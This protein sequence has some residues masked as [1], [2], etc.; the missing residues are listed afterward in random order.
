MKFIPY[1]VP[2]ELSK[3]NKFALGLPADYGPMFKQATTLKAAIWAARNVETQIR[4]KVLER[5][6]VGEK[7][8]IDGFSGSSKKS[9]FSKS[10]SRGSGGKI[11]VKWCDKCKKKRMGS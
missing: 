11:E 5:S 8:K 6:E 4:E 3:V 7:R 1:L 10:G 2:T 9:K